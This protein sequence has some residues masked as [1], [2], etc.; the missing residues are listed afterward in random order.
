[1]AQL[2]PLPPELRRERDG[3]ITHDEHL[4]LDRLFARRAGYAL[5]S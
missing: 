2:R 4:P 3:T 1:M 5:A